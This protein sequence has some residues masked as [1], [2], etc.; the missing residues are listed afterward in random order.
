LF[1]PEEEEDSDAPY[2]IS[3]I[4]GKVGDFGLSL[5]LAPDASG[6]LSSWWV[7]IFK[8]TFFNILPFASSLYS[9]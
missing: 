7:K 8:A 2:D 4:H 3:T 1:G 5:A 9:G 6:I